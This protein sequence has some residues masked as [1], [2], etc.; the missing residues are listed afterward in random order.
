MTFPEKL[1][2]IITLKCGGRH[3]MLAEA[4]GVNMSYISKLKGG[5][6]GLG[7]QQLKRLMIAFPDLNPR[8]LILDD[9]NE[10]M[11]DRNDLIKIRMDLYQNI[12]TMLDIEHFLPYMS[13]EELFSYQDSVKMIKPFNYT[14]DQ[15]IRWKT[16]RQKS[17]EIK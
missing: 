7:L 16:S 11:F 6:V 17:E 8:W 15:L 10:E 14:D 3:S 1:E 4:M 12:K 5:D 2:Q 9:P 13:K